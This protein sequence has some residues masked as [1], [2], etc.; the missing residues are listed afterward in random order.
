MLVKVLVF[1]PILVSVSTLEPMRCSDPFTSDTGQ[2]RQQ[3]AERYS[4]TIDLRATSTKPAPCPTR[5]MTLKSLADQ[6]AQNNVATSTKAESATGD[7]APYLSS[8]RIPDVQVYNQ[9]GKQRSFYSDIV[10]G[11]TVAINFIFTTCTTVCPQLT[12]TFRRV[13]QSLSEGAL[14]VQL[15][16]ISVDPTIDT[17]ERLHEFATKFKPGPGWIFVTGGKSE[18]EALLRALGAGLGAKE[19]HTSI[20]LIGNDVTNNWTRISGLSPPAAI[21]KVI[22]EVASHKSTNDLSRR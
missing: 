21:V 16:S 12:A 19:S 22:K 14:R 10:K 13:Q 3:K 20:I 18:I 2:R 4:C 6:V 5:D 1:L 8:S 7:T 9:D 15:I 17:P 11:N